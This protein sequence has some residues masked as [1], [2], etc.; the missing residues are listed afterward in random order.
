MGVS[1]ISKERKLPWSRWPWH[2]LAAD[3]IQQLPPFSLFWPAR[4][5]QWYD[6]EKITLFWR[7]YVVCSSV[8]D[9]GKKVQPILHSFRLCKKV[10]PVAKLRGSQVLPAATSRSL[11]DLW[12]IML[13]SVPWTVKWLFTCQSKNNSRKSQ[14]D[15]KSYL[16]PLVGQHW[17]YLVYL[18]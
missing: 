17:Q 11:L 3:A 6:P 18:N 7:S 13:I 9:S 2:D 16:R 15:Q 4:T 14:L 10:R 5:L 1:S 8:F 12:S